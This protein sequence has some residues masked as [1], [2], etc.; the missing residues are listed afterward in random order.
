MAQKKNTDNIENTD[1]KSAASVCNIMH[2]NATNIIEK[3]ESLLPANMQ[4][5]SDFYTEC[6][7]SLQDL[8]GVC[9]MTENEILPK[10]G[11]DQK[12]LQSFGAYAKTAAGSAIT[13]IEMANNIQKTYLQT[14]I[15]AVKTMDEYIRLML[16]SYSKMLAS[17][18]GIYRKFQ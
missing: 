16:D 18:L 8:F 1:T 11:I 15:S 7:H 5:Y 6:L 13:Q 17:S 3:M 2:T 14:Q 12:A 4:M 10:M 9:Y